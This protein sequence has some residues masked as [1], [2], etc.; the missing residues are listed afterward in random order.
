M[1]LVDHGVHMIDLFP[2]LT[3]SE[4]VSVMGRGNVSG[5]TPATEFVYMTLANGAVGQLLYNDCTF[6]TDLPVEG[7]FSH[8]AA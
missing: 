3:D 2:W 7:I 5:E 6:D 1:G 4:I 8:G